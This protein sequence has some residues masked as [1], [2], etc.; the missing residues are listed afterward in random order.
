MYHRPFT[1]KVKCNSTPLS[2]SFTQHM[3]ELLA[4]NC[5]AVL[6]WHAQGQQIS[7][8]AALCA[9]KSNKTNC[10]QGTHTHQG[11]NS[12]PWPPLPGDMAVS[13]RCGSILS[14]D[15]IFFFLFLGMV[16]YDNNMIMSLKQKERKFEP[17]IKLNHNTCMRYW[18]GHGLVYFGL[19]Y[20]TWRY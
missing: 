14:L 9:S 10:K 11:S 6:P 1:A 5:M 7:I 17:R 3:W 13:M 16:M 2:A 4:G 19:V 15:Q 8:Y 20:Y 18:P 12:C